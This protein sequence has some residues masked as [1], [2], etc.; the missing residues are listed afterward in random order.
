MPPFQFT[1]KP[2]PADQK[3]LTAQN[4]PALESKVRRKAD[5]VSRRQSME[6]T[7]HAQVSSATL[8]GP[9]DPSL[10]GHESHY[11]NGMVDN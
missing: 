7:V 6:L 10:E 4:I 1:G 8:Y 9:R 5:I 3:M 2:S 11:E